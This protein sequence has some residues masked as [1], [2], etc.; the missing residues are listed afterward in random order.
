VPGTGNGSYPPALQLA[1]RLAQGRPVRV[2]GVYD[3]LSALAASRH[4]FDAVWLSG[5]GVSAALGLPDASIASLTDFLACARVVRRCTTLPVIA[6]ADS[7]F[8]DV[9]TVLHLMA[10]Y[11]RIGVAAVCI[12]DKVFPKRNSFAG[13]QH[14]ADPGHFAAMLTAAA[15]ARGPGAP[16]LIARLE[17]LVAGTGLADA[18]TRAAL[19]VRAGA[20]ALLVHSRA[21]TPE[22]VIAF[23]G[24]F[25][26]TDVTTPLLAVPTTYPQVHAD[27]LHE[28]GYAAV[29][30]ANQLLRGF[31][32]CA[33]QLLTDIEYDGSTAAVE[34]RLASTGTLLTLLGSDLVAARDAEH[35]RCAAEYRT[36]QEQLVVGPR[37]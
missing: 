11:H 8:G 25:R 19:Y 14:L 32:A 18:L 2:V 29:I 24:E 7:G 16:M 33:E 37:P 30:Y 26:R 17:S 21:D 35:D 20:D 22:E 15:A 6:D 1:S 23:A 28:A 12:E 27:S 31:L 4:G 5:L 13:A 3:G 36:A 34:S 9:N 10:E